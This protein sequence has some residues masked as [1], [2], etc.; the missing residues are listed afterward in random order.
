MLN[1]V[2]ILDKYKIRCVHREN[3]FERDKRSEISFKKKTAEIQAYK[4]KVASLD[5]SYRV[6]KRR[7]SLLTRQKMKMRQIGQKNQHVLLKQRLKGKKSKLQRKKVH[8]LAQHEPIDQ[9]SLWQ[10]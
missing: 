4:G 7:F 6:M 9:G 1:N 5:K 2:H 3:V 8:L 10:N